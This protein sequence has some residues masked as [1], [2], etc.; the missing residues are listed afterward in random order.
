MKTLPLR[1]YTIWCLKSIVARVLTIQI[2]DTNPR[3]LSFDEITVMKGS[4]LKT[5]DGQAKPNTYHGS[6]GNGSVMLNLG[7]IEN[8]L[9][10][11]QKFNVLLFKLLHLIR[12]A[13]LDWPCFEVA[14]ALQNTRCITRIEPMQESMLRNKRL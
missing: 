8:D 10:F 2:L 3:V 11:R 7:L 12:F 13:Y 14:Q 5:K 9:I 6:P 1:E 4:F